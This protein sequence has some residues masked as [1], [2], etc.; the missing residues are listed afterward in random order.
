MCEAQHDVRPDPIL[1]DLD[2]LLI[3]LLCLFIIF[4]VDAKEVIISSHMSIKSLNICLFLL[5]IGEPV[6][7][8]LGLYALHQ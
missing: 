1:I 6:P 5:P 4:F 3:K 8:M 2:S 7:Q